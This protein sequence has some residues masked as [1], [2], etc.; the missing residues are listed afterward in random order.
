[1]NFT[2]K[3]ALL[4]LM[5]AGLAALAV[6]WVFGQPLLFLL[7][8]S[9]AYACWSLYNLVRLERWLA[10]GKRRNPPDVPGLWGNIFYRIHRLQIKN[11]K[12]K[13]HFAQ[14]LR[15][16]RKSTAAMPDGTVIL[17]EH[18][19]IEWFNRAAAN[20]LGLGLKKDS[21]QRI[22]NLI[23]HPE[24]VEYLDQEKF[25]RAIEIRSPV[26]ENMRLAIQIVTYGRRDQRLML[27]K[28]VTQLAN[29]ERTRRDFVANASHELRTPLTVISGY[30]E[31]MAE[32]QDLDELWHEPIK[33]MQAQSANMTHIISDLLELSRLES[34]QSAAPRAAV[35]FASLL[36]QVR[37]EVM[38]SSG[39]QVEIQL[40][41]NTSAKVLGSEKEL[42]SVFSNL[43]SNAVKFSEPGTR[44]QVEWSL[45]FD[46]GV[47]S[48][49]DEG[50]G[51]P[52]ESIPRLTERF[53]R[54][55]AGRSKQRGG[56]GLGLAIVKHALSRHEADL[57]VDSELGQGSVFSCYFPADRIKKPAE[58]AHL[59]A[60]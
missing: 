3:T 2:W 46:Q 55:D 21:G 4:R 20:L 31:A 60:I 57:S 28:D 34:M 36:Q 23:R 47:L 33:Q 29:L 6:G 35:D 51:I 11:R 41:L 44:V 53:Y 19:Q 13:R 32:D 50:I 56:T 37:S 18:N 16:F 17:N 38:A 42:H 40:K 8:F 49:R 10:S 15:E 43:I 1:M 22:D 52:K 27:I 45:D 24:F 58:R 5:A 59:R 54:V 26:R 9:V 14:L 7:L 48:V 12:R 39:N 30:L 25:D